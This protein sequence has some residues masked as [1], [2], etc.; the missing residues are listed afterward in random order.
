[1]RIGYAKQYNKSC[2]ILEYNDKIEDVIEYANCEDAIYYEDGPDDKC[3]VV[4]FPNRPMELYTEN[5]IRRGFPVKI[6]VES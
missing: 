3:F 1:M 2:I 5:A 4:Q 6:G